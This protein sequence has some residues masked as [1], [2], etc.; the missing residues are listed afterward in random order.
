MQT[1]SAD[2]LHLRVCSEL[3]LYPAPGGARIALPNK[4]L[5]L[6]AFLAME[7]GVHTR[8]GLS[9]MLWAESDE[10]HASMS[11]RQALSKLREAV[12]GAAGDALFADRINVQLRPGAGLRCD[13]LD[14]VSA[15]ERATLPSTM[16]PVHCA[17][18]G[19]SV[20]DAPDFGHW[21]DRTR[22][23][24]V[25]RATVALQR[26]VVES[27]A[28]RDW[29]QVQRAAEG[30]LLFAPVNPDA[31]CAAIE[32]AF[33]RRN[34]PRALAIRDEFIGRLGVEGLLDDGVVARIRAVERRYE[35]AGWRTPARGVAAATLS[36]HNGNGVPAL[37][38]TPF[39]TTLRER[40]AVWQAIS[41]AFDRVTQSESPEVLVLAGGVG[42]GRTRLLED[43]AA[44]SK[45]REAT[46]L[47][48]CD[49]HQATVMPF[50]ALATLVR[51]TLDVPGLGGVD[52][53]ALKVL[54]A[55]LPELGRR[56]PHL[57]GMSTADSMTDATFALRVQEAL[58][59]AITSMA[60][61]ATVVIV[62]DDDVWFD[63]ESAGIL[64]ALMQRSARLPVL[65]IMT[66]ADDPAMES[67]NPMWAEAVR[68]GERLELPALAASSI[69]EM[70]AEFSGMADGWDALAD[71]VHAATH[72][73][74]GFVVACLEAL[75][76]SHGD[77]WAAVQM[78]AVRPPVLPLRQQQYIEAMDDFTRL[79][80]LSLA[81]VAES[82]HP[83]PAHRWTA[84]PPLTLDILSHVHGISRLRA[85]VEGQRL[86][87][88]CLAEEV[89]SG[90]RCVSP[91]V[92]EY[93]LT[94][95]STLVRDEVRR[96][97]QAFVP[98]TPVAHSAVPHMAVPH[99]AVPHMAVPRVAGLPQQ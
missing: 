69:V 88:A 31:A 4:S 29:A 49:S 42:S 18:G 46:V 92:V 73:V 37:T 1:A 85:A 22:A 52:Q 26:C 80:L 39:A 86:V 62:L 28:R 54:H 56:F 90:F 11:L 95:G 51:E 23:R 45:S 48:T 43:A 93:M 40:D 94:T 5:A 65:W 27:G 59:Q 89:T 50:S 8:A 82:D 33:M 12:G 97:L 2:G 67:T 9:A 96:L 24:L 6:L 21:A 83:V 14:F 60:E 79:V 87:A 3:G 66:T 76:L 16:V 58:A 91:V 15:L 17:F 53:G 41:A 32:A 78:A 34:A 68:M 84:L 13:A 98:Q 25:R 10:S 71:R 63:R 99:M 64:L 30:W 57:R 20:D 36:S 19:L 7:P 81:L 38:R 61:D 44:W 70:C 47:S 35:G 72:G 75:R 55:L 74:P 77:D